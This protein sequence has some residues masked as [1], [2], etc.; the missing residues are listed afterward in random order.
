MFVRGIEDA[1]EAQALSNLFPLPIARLVEICAVEGIESGLVLNLRAIK[2]GYGYG[3][4]A[5]AFGIAGGIIPLLGCAEV[6]GEV[7]VK[8]LFGVFP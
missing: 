6:I 7:L 1:D 8:L 2:G 4:V 5:G 3:L